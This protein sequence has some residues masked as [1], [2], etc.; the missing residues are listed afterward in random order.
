MW[1][2]FFA[3]LLF[4]IFIHELAHML[5]ALKCGVGVKTFSV[6]FWKPYLHKTIKGIDYR[7]S[8]WLIGGYCDLKG[9]DSKKCSDDF[10]NQKYFKKFLILIAGIAVNFI[11]ACIC[12]LINY[13]SILI[14]MQIDWMLIKSTFVKTYT[15]MDILFLASNNVGANFT[16]LQLGLLNFFCAIANI[17]PIPALDGGHLWLVLMEKIW[18]EKFIKRYTIITKIC[19]WIL[20]LI[21]IPLLIWVWF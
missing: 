13:K 2:E 3:C 10:L 15:N 8:P 18:K 19:F 6:G 7:I 17:L 1:F 14:G 16:L 21:Q 4:T 11:I 5:V 9:M 20:L 12:Y